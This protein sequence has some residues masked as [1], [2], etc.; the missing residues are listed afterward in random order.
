MSLD[1]IT[2]TILSPEIATP[3]PLR[4]ITGITYSIG[5]FFKIYSTQVNDLEVQNMIFAL[6]ATT[7]AGSTIDNDLR[8]SVEYFTGYDNTTLN[9]TISVRGIAPTTTSFFG[10]RSSQHFAMFGEQVDY[11]VHVN[12]W[13]MMAATHDHTTQERK[14]YLI[15]CDTGTTI[16][17]STTTAA[18]AGA[19][20]TADYQY[21][22]MGGTNIQNLQLGTDEYCLKAEDW[23]VDEV[24][25]E[26]DL[27]TIS[28]AGF[29]ADSHPTT[30]LIDLNYMLP[31]TTT[32]GTDTS[33]TPARDEH[34]VVDQ[35]SG[36]SL[37]V[38]RGVLFTSTDNPVEVLKI[39]GVSPSNTSV[40]VTGFSV[41]TEDAK[42]VAYPANTSTPSAANVYNEVGAT[43][44]SSI[45]F[46]GGTGGVT[47]TISGLSSD[48]SYDIYLVQEDGAS[49][50]I[51]TDETETTT[52]TSL[53]L[54]LTD[55]EGTALNN[56]ADIE[57]AIFVGTAA[58]ALGTKLDSGLVTM[59]GD[60]ITIAVTGASSG[61]NVVVMLS[62][63]G[64][65]YGTYPATLS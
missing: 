19:V 28:Q 58:N 21:L 61:D 60:S 2:S 15:D 6:Q 45:V 64:V 33:V 55:I 29:V 47:A 37:R 22:I 27:Q 40:D 24:L 26:S 31:L 5:S 42:V 14:A 25:S 11:S 30:C 43:A 1:I 52:G 9:S 51:L 53:T 23:L 3:S 44:A 13:L 20:T 35:V 39:T 63:A 65:E 32:V 12:K 59:V 18:F 57:Y 38:A 8:L 36:A 17:S 16:H 46:T 50:Y 10:S 56:V 4:S 41:L 54:A 34:F 62:K 7:G 49:G 48:T